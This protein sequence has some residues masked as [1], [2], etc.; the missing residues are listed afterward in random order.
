[1]FCLG[2]GFDSILIDV[3]YNN[4]RFGFR[5]NNTDIIMDGGSDGDY[6]ART[7]QWQ[8]VALVRQSGVYKMYIDGRLITATLQTVMV[9]LI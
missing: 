5:Y 4:Y 7:Y 6:L 9:V 8:H 1:M 3:N 2:N